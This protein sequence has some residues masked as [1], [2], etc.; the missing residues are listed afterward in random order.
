MDAIPNRNRNSLYSL[1]PTILLMLATPQIAILGWVIP[2]IGFPA[3]LLICA[4]VSL[5]GV[6]IIRYALTLEKPVVNCEVASADRSTDN[7]NQEEVHDI[8]QTE[9]LSEELEHVVTS[10]QE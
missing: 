6:L 2:V 1:Q 7:E 4:A 8:S 5:I 9:D 3:T 10:S